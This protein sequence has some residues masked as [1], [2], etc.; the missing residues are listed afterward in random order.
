MYLYKRLR[1]VSTIQMVHGGVYWTLFLP[2]N[3]F[4]N[5][6]FLT[7]LVTVRLR[8]TAVR[9]RACRQQFCSLCTDILLLLP[10]KAGVL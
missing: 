5:T 9:N 10:N 6:N 4:P 8:K 7:S 1:A 2:S 3:V